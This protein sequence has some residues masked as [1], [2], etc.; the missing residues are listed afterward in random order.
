LAQGYNRFVAHRKLSAVVLGIVL[1]IL[2][3]G[4]PIAAHH[5]FA[6]AFDATNIVQIKGVL[7]R[8]EWTNPH[9]HLFLDVKDSGGRV[10]NWSCEG[11]PPSV[12]VR[13]GLTRDAL[14]VGDLLVVDGYRAKNGT[15]SLL[16]LRMILPDGRTITTP[17]AGNLPGR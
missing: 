6:A 4:T 8:I 10:S 9:S 16:A 11:G 12:L 7:T 17:A 3:A 2:G 15:P 5:Y 13:I 1:V 14:K